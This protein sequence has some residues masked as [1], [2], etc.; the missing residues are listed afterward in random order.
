MGICLCE[1]HKTHEL[2]RGVHK[3]RKTRKTRKR[4]ESKSVPTRTGGW[5]GR[6]AGMEEAIGGESLLESAEVGAIGLDEADGVGDGAVGEVDAAGL[7][8]LRE[9]G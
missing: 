8:R 1:V 5:S 6:S 4:R 9:H 3:T 7:T 2:R